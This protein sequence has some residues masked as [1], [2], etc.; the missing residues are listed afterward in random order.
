[1]KALRD[2]LAVFRLYRRHHSIGYAARIAYGCAF[3]K[4]PF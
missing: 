4:F 2:F 1:M 3:R